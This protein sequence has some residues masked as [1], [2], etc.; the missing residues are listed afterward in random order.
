MTGDGPVALSS[1][2]VDALLESVDIPEGETQYKFF[3]PT[4]AAVERWVE[5]AKGSH[6][7]FYLGLTDIDQKMNEVCFVGAEARILGRCP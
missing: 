1:E 5:Y 2:D 7:C 3:R 4:A 6:D